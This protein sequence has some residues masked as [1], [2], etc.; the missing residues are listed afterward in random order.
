MEDEELI[1]DEQITTDN[2]HLDIQQQEQINNAEEDEQMAIIQF[3]NQRQ[4][5][6]Q[7]PLIVKIERGS[8]ESY[9]F[10]IIIQP[11]C[12]FFPM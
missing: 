4:N 3:R 7:S 10:L 12:H 8:L 11:F 5:T 1:G 9:I 2:I 6:E